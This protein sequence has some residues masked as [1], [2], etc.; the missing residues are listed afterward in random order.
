VIETHDDNQRAL[1]DDQ[2]DLASGGAMNHISAHHPLPP[3]TQPHPEPQ[4]GPAT[5]R[6]LRPRC[7]TGAAF[8]STCRPR[9]FTR[10][11]FQIK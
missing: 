10:R 11:S 5:L 2:L 1:R 8:L 6:Q 4:A 9:N 3:G 7:S